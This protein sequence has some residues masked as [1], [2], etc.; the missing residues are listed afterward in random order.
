MKHTNSSQQK[1]NKNQETSN[2]TKEQTNG[3]ATQSCIETISEQADNPLMDTTNQEEST[4][5]LEN[6]STESNNKNQENKSSKLPPIILKENKYSYSKIRNIFN[7]KNFK[8][9]GNSIPDGIKITTTDP[10]TY[11]AMVKILKDLGVEHHSY[12]LPQDRK[13]KIV[14]KGLLRSTETEEIK[15]ELEELNFQPEEIKQMTKR[16]NGEV[17]KLPLFLVTL[18]KNE[19]SKEN[20]P[21]KIPMWIKN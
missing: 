10:D 6:P 19:A 14:I 8:F 16:R 3:N 9:I 7:Q 11:R 4:I 18:P 15:E 12:I 20:I 1:E 13:L 5:N 17:S 21:N 2:A